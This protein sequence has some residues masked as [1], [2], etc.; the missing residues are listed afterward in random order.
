[1]RLRSVVWSVVA[2][3]FVA[4]V[5]AGFIMVRRGFSARDQPTAVDVLAAGTMRR[6]AV[7]R[8]ARSLANPGLRYG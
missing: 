5:A 7:P 1:M 8:Q 4:A 3:V 2:V 6:L